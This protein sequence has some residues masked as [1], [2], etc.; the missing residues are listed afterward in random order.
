MDK[1]NQDPNLGL[2]SQ[3]I[4]LNLFDPV[5]GIRDGKIRIRD[6]HSG[7]TTLLPVQESLTTRYWLGTIYKVPDHTVLARYNI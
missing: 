3:I 1:K 5:S 4:F 2:T 7:S 6:K